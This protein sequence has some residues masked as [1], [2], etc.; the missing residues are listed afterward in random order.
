MHSIGI[1]KSPL[2]KK[3][4]KRKRE[5]NPNFVFF[6][7]FEL[8]LCVG[9]G[10]QYASFD[11]K[12]MT[13]VKH[14]NESSLRT[15]ICRTLYGCVCVCVNARLWR[16][17]LTVPRWQFKWRLACFQ[18]RLFFSKAVCVW[19]YVRISPYNSY[20]LVSWCPISQFSGRSEVMKFYILVNF[21][22]DSVKHWIIDHR[23]AQRYS[24]WDCFVN[25]RIC[26]TLLTFA[27]RRKVLQ[28]QV[29]DRRNCNQ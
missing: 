24:I 9:F 15:Q 11:D 25:V 13:K 22:G 29:S 7:G 14:R 28:S 23:V 21:T 10:K 17:A 5:K 18:I 20:R 12:W 6:S 1:T 16:I 3:T 2:A 19:A 8:I 27:G 4:K 26:T